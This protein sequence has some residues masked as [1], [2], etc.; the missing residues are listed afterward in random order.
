MQCV[1]VRA[2]VRRVKQRGWGSSCGWNEYHQQ[3]AEIVRVLQ[4]ARRVRVLPSAPDTCFFLAGIY[5]SYCSIFL[6][7]RG[8]PG[9]ESHA[10]RRGERR[11]T[12][13]TQKYGTE[14]VNEGW[15]LWVWLQWK[16]CSLNEND[17][18]CVVIVLGEDWFWDT[19]LGVW[20]HNL[21][22]CVAPKFV[23]ERSARSSVI[24]VEFNWEIIGERWL[25]CTSA[26]AE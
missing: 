11:L 3:V 9:F 18:K 22:L 1:C 16:F 4:S 21:K 26:L 20:G 7:I 24:T 12:C 13:L 5:T 6:R 10:A 17:A 8:W 25:I 23:L 15:K 14:P 2:C 19:V